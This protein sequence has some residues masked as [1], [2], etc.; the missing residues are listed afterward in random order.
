MLAALVNI[1]EAKASILYVIIEKNN[2]ERMEKAD[3]ITLESIP[4]GGILP[5]VMFPDNF[6]VLIAYEPN[7][8]ELY[9]KARKGGVEFTAY[10]ERGRVF[11]PKTDG[12]ENA[13]PIVTEDMN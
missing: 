9:A 3:P 12:P 6:S 10:L 11:D 4:K 2:L 1:P 7:A 5:R 13:R 8:E